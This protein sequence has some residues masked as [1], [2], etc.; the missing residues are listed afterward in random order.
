M[1]YA[2]WQTTSI[3]AL[4]ETHNYPIPDF[5]EIDIEG[6][7]IAVL[8]GAEMTISKH[9]PKLLVATH[10]D[11]EREFVLK[12]L[13]AH[14]YRYEILNESATKGDTEIMAWPTQHTA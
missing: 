4:V 5:I 7:E 8:N 1:D 13:D 14:R 6:G 10:G 11:A 3:D 12:F 2:V 9:R